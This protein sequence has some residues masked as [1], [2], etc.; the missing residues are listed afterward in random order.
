MKTSMALKQE[1]QW[2]L[3]GALSYHGE[4][5]EDLETAREKELPSKEHID[6]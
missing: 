6:L 5:K 3:L 2:V 4:T 1:S